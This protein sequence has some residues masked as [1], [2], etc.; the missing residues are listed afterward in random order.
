M[1]VICGE[2]NMCCFANNRRSLPLSYQTIDNMYL[3]TTDLVIGLISSRLVT[4]E[5]F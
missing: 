2:Y 5:H 1:N 4:L 3:S